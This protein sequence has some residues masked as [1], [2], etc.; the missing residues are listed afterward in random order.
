MKIHMAGVFSFAC[1]VYT[2]GNPKLCILPWRHPRHGTS[3]QAP[4]GRRAPLY[5]RLHFW[6]SDR[7]LGHFPRTLLYQMQVGKFP[8]LPRAPDNGENRNQSLGKISRDK[9]MSHLYKFQSDYNCAL[10]L[11]LGNRWGEV[12]G[13]I[14][15]MHCDDLVLGLVS[16]HTVF[17]VCEVPPIPEL[18]PGRCH[19][20]STRRA[21]VCGGRRMAWKAKPSSTTGRT[22]S[23]LGAILPRSSAFG[24]SCG[25]LCVAGAK[26]QC[27]LLFYSTPPV[28]CAHHCTDGT[29][30][31]WPLSLF[32]S[33]TLAC[34]WL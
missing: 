16:L 20:R 30:W 2:G 8:V 12:L 23:N 13:A 6:H 5:P 3:V 27:G 24:V 22:T 28:V 18:D 15:C 7:G 19:R 11:Y 29:P 4:A 26:L 10:C 34:C 14:K 31:P 25:G 33:T 1:E 9:P 17:P 21:F 32:A